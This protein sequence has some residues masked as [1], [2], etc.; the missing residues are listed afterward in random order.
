MKPFL[1][2][3]SAVL[4]TSLVLASSDASGQIMHVTRDVEKTVGP[5]PPPQWRPPVIN[6][7]SRPQG[8]GDREVLF[9]H[10]LGGER[11][12]WGAVAAD[13]GHRYELN[14]DLIDYGD[15]Q[16]QTIEAVSSNVLSLLPDEHDRAQDVRDQT[17]FV[18]HS[19]GG[20]V[21]R[22]MIREQQATGYTAD[23]K[24]YGGLVTFHSPHGGAPI[25]ADRVAL[26]N[27]FSE[28]CHDLTDGP[29]RA[30]TDGLPWFIKFNDYDNVEPGERPER[31]HIYAATQQFVD[32]GCT[33]TAFDLAFESLVLSRTLPRVADD[34]A[35]GA[36]FI[37]EIADHGN[38]FGLATASIVGFEEQP[39]ALKLFGSAFSG[40]SD[41]DAYSANDDSTMFMFVR[42]EQISNYYERSRQKREEADRINPFWLDPW[43]GAKIRK[44]N[45]LYA[46]SEAFARGARWWVGLN[47]SW[48]SLVGATE[49]R[50]RPPTYRCDCTSP[51][52]GNWQVEVPTESGCRRQEWMNSAGASCTATIQYHNNELVYLPSDGVVP[53]TNQQAWETDVSW[54]A[55][56]SNHLQIRNDDNTK[57][58]FDVHIFQG[59]E[60]RLRI[61]TR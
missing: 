44:K 60:P 26:N 30:L 21:G 12:A 25:A 35:P 22:Q 38:P 47:E 1:P 14:Y 23:T 46:T 39:A 13:L 32:N 58:A 5:I 43:Y 41:A 42:R 16:G 24:F 31:R 59:E 57:E 27:F 50:S 4:A 8:P 28:A 18:G 15:L 49:R 20:L 10:G 36:D 56:G 37:D 48:L 33:G 61:P 45:R 19:L 40:V 54:R 7:P 29:I 52:R 2:V 34:L 11:A 3:I 17:I 6:P 51:A 55:E 53:L 9:A